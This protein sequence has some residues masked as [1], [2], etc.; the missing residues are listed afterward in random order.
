MR[1]ALVLTAAA[2]LAPA[3]AFAADP[4]PAAKPADPPITFQTHPFERVLNDIRF[5]AD[6]V[7]GE[8]AVKAFNKAIK[9]Q[10]GDKGFEGLDLGKPIVGYVLLAPKPADIT[11]VIAFPI[12]GEKEFIA[13]CDR[14][15]GG[16]K[17]K[18]LGKGLYE[19][20]PLNPRYKARMKFANQ[21][22]Y[23]AYGANP[24]P[25]LD[26][27]VIVAPE[28]LYDPAENALFTGKLHFD[29][30]TPEVKKAI[31]VYVAEIKKEFG[32]D[33]NRI[34]GVLGKILQ[35]GMPDIEKMLARYALLL[36]GGADTAALR[37]SIDLPTSDFVVDF[38]VTPKPNTPLAKVISEHKPGGNQFA[39]LLKPDTVA[40]FKTRLPFFNDE[41]KAA[42]VKMLEE[43]QK[44]ANQPGAPK[45]M[46]DELFKGLIR[47]VKTGEA[48]IVAGIRGP[49]KTGE[50]TLVAAIAFDDPSALEK[51]FKKFFEKDAPQTEQDR[52][53]WDADKAGKVS[54]HTFSFPNE[55]GF[56]NPAKIFGGD[57]CKLAFAFAPKGI[58]FVLGPDPIPVM[59]DALA[60]KPEE[61]PM[62]DVVLNPARMG[63]L[64]E[65]GGGQALEVERALG[66]EDKLLS[67]TS[68]RVSGGKELNVKY[69]I[70]LRLLPRALFVSEDKS[71]P[72][73]A[74]PP[75][76]GK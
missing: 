51:E 42:G 55:R 65:K 56:L 30:L 6:L 11:A 14:W 46:L 29:R 19:V 3:P 38:T 17:A 16:E 48:D 73:E 23:V 7:G 5:A 61:S 1:Y 54:I 20:P 21:Y 63:K 25:A 27:K 41:L 50:F 4:A 52:M 44:Q 39:G 31:P 67:A 76:I 70:N 26:A 40:G 62:L 35:A 43:G 59:K 53:K 37:L 68:L 18:D 32:R 72:G 15:N 64:I 74:P 9:D 33:E 75:P 71:A 24:E 58:F 8:K 28:K 49:D 34:D 45:D 57:Q 69:A 22:A 10:L 66:K 12:T 2:I 47:T 36:L 60:I 13:L